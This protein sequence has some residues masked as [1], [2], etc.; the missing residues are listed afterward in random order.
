[1]SEQTENQEVTAPVSDEEAA[2][3]AHLN[4]QVQ[5]EQEQLAPTS[6]PEADAPA[7]PTLQN[8]LAGLI[9]MA[10]AL[11]G[12][13]LPSLTTIYTPDTTNA[14]AGAVASLC[15]KYGWLQNGIANG[16]GEEIAAAMVLLP[17]GIATYQGVNADLAALQAKK[18]PELPSAAPTPELESA[19]EAAPA[20][21]EQ[22]AMVGLHLVDSVPGV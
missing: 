3:L 17:V 22:T 16:Y 21:E 20:G 14:V 2:S 15:T 13:I 8:E 10:V 18:K 4:A 6:E 5:K 19:E 1:M 11:A 7:V 9:G 12:P